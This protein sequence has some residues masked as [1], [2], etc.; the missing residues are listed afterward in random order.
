MADTIHTTASTRRDQIDYFAL[1]T[2]IG[3]TKLKCVASAENPS[4]Q[5]A[6][7]QNSVGDTVVVD[8]YALTAAPSAEYE[9][10]GAISGQAIT[11]GTVDSSNTVIGTANLPVA[12]G[13]FSISTQN[14][15][16]PT[17]S[18]SG[19]ALFTG[20]TQLRAYKLPAIS[21]TA[22]H[23]AQDIFTNPLVTIKYNSGATVAS[24]LF[25]Y[26]LSQVNANFPVEFTTAMPGGTM[27]GYDLHGGT[28]T[29]DYTL[30]WYRTDHQ[31]EIAINTASYPNAKI[32]IQIGTD[33]YFASP[34]TLTVHPGRTNARESY[35]Q[36]TFQVSFPLVGAE[37]A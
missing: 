33:E 29:V 13:S 20:A 18:A 10:I 36:Y 5:T 34:M 3:A 17:I 28:V 4:N 16:A 2:A 22:R 12:L 31:P 27:L 1:V 32:N 21:L 30:N 35:T 11:L 25:D 37:A 15:S 24:P 7:G 9:V 19:Q 26:G 6:S 14:G 8:S 23:R